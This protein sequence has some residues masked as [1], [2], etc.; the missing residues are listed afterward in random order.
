MYIIKESFKNYEDLVNFDG[1]KESF[2][3]L[4]DYLSSM[5]L[6]QGRAPRNMVKEY[7]KLLFMQKQLDSVDLYYH[8]DTDKALTSKSN[9]I[10]TMSYLSAHTLLLLH[11]KLSMK[12]DEPTELKLKNAKYINESIM[13]YKNFEAESKYIDNFLSTLKGFHSKVLKDL[14]IVFVKKEQSKAGATY[15]TEKDVIFIRPDKLIHGDKYASFIYVVLHEL[16]HRYLRFNKVNF[17]YTSYE[18]ITTK[19]S[20]SESWNDEEKFAELFALS[21][22]EYKGEPFDSF[23][24]KIEKFN[25][26][27][28]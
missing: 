4:K 25:K 23:S 11:D 28:K 12:Q 2:L 16:G 14:H 13:T 19:Y 20:K 22:F 5:N 15:K 3:L 1:S 9:I 27:M 10:A 24:D 17:D 7:E 6:K 26:V 8:G 21:H 18:W